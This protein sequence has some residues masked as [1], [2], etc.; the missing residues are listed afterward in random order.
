MVTEVISVK[1]PVR[2]KIFIRILSSVCREERSEREKMAGKLHLLQEKLRRMRADPNHSSD[3]EE[4]SARGAAAHGT[5]ARAMPFRVSRGN[6]GRRINY[7]IINF[8]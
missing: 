4:L 6:T 1:S 2:C 3:D 8:V 5:G 7:Q